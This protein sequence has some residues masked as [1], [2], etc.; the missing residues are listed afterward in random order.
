MDSLIPITKISQIQIM[1]VVGFTANTIYCMY[2][3]LKYRTV[4]HIEN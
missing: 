3:F 4:S 1:L 2:Q